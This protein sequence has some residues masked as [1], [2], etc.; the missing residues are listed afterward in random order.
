MNHLKHEVRISASF[1][2][3]EG[4][5]LKGLYPLGMRGQ[6]HIQLLLLFC[7]AFS[8]RRV[9]L[10][11]FPIWNKFNIRTHLQLKSFSNS[12]QIKNEW[13]KLLFKQYS[14]RY[15]SVHLEGLFWSE[16]VRE[17]A[18]RIESPLRPRS[19][20]RGKQHRGSVLEVVGGRRACPCKT[21]QP[22]AGKHSSNA[23]FL[24]CNF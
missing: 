9:L 16:I 5:D 21:Q 14:K 12:K 18:A 17:W 15:T 19:S 20:L 1:S 22:G 4:S 2:D 13:P 6:N 7:S 23:C 10:V 3:S 11:F 8:F 24:H